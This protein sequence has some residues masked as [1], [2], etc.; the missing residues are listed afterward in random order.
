MVDERARASPL[1]RARERRHGL[2]SAMS[3]LERALAAPASAGDEWATAERRQLERLPAAF[4]RHVANAESDGGLFEDVIDHA[5]RLVRRVDKLHH[6]HD[7]VTIELAA[8]A[9]GS[10]PRW[11]PTPSPLYGRGP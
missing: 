3:E 10:T 7:T 11:T 2:R 5:P 8:L 6:D 4:E 1:S 9:S